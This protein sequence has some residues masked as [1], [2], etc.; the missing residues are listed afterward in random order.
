MTDQVKTSS[1]GSARSGEIPNVIAN[2]W[3]GHVMMIASSLLF[4][5]D[6]RFQQKIIAN[7]TESDLNTVLFGSRLI[8]FL[9]FQTPDIMA[10]NSSD[11]FTEF[12]VDLEGRFPPDALHKRRTHPETSMP[13]KRCPPTDARWVKGVPSLVFD[14][15]ASPDDRIEL[16]AAHFLRQLEE[17]ES[18]IF[19]LTGILRSLEKRTDF[20]MSDL[21]KLWEDWERRGARSRQENTRP[22][23][24]TRNRNV[25][26]SSMPHR[27]TVRPTT[28]KATPPD[29]TPDTV[30]P[31]F[32]ATPAV[33]GPV[34]RTYKAPPPGFGPEPNIGPIPKTPPPRI[35]SAPGTPPYKA[36]PS[37]APPLDHARPAPGALPYK[38]PPSD[39]PP[40]DHARPAPRTPPYKAPPLDNA[41]PERVSVLRP[42]T[43]PAPAVRPKTEPDRSRTPVQAMPYSGPTYTD[44]GHSIG[45]KKMEVG[46]QMK[47]GPIPVQFLI[48]TLWTS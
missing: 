20:H 29:M 7:I 46:Q 37:D 28:P 8:L 26:D 32:K 15:N 24:T 39:A 21:S 45:D 30:P 38:A 34:S 23:N 43:V 22:D 16:M 48:L 27:S 4:I 14:R 6:F 42:Y 3:T 35:F 19:M 25:P 41:R 11:V 33:H 10:I 40:L 12:G 17:A 31:K 47:V 18:K 9:L 1:G 36:P 5:M 44:H 2:K 13:W